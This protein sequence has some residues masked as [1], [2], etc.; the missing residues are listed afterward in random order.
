VG[1]GH[2]IAG[3]CII[4]RPDTTIVVGPDQSVEMEPYGNFVISIARNQ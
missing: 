1:P 4:E 2:A 3:P